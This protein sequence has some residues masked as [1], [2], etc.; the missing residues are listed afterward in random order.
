MVIGVIAI[1]KTCMTENYDT[2]EEDSF[3]ALCKFEA[4][5]WKHLLLLLP[6]THSGVGSTSVL[7]SGWNSKLLVHL[8]IRIV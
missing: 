3:E 4:Q 8:E 6:V 1:L 5:S 7:V 2:E